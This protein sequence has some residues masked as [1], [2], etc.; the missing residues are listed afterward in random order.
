MARRNP[1]RGVARLSLTLPESGVARVE[2]FDVGGAR[3][4]TLLDG[5]QPAGTR[6]LSWDAG[7]TSAGVYF[8]RVAFARRSTTIRLV[9]VR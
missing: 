1:V 3:V 5:W 4:A 8:A 7:D 9:L 2:V 6:E